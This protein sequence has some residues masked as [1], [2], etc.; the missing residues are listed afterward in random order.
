MLGDSCRRPRPAPRLQRT[1]S[2]T[3]TARSGRPARSSASGSGPGRGGSS[4]WMWSN[5]PG[6]GPIA[7]VSAQQPRL[8][9]P[10]TAQG[11]LP[12]TGASAQSV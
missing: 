7:A 8:R 12:A 11:H 2:A 6:D 5:Y 9:L 1:S 10:K 4:G 3:T